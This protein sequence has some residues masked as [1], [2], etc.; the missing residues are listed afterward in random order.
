MTSPLEPEPSTAAADFGKGLALIGYRGTGKSTIG[1][2]VARRAGRKFLDLDREIE[3]R[4]ARPIHAIFLEK[5]EPAFRDLEESVLLDL[6]VQHDCVLA[7]GGGA[8]LRESNRRGLRNFGLIVWLTASCEVLARRLSHDGREGKAR[9]AL[10][11]AG[12]LAEIETVLT[13]RLPLY[14]LAADARVETEGRPASRVAEDVLQLWVDW[15][16]AGGRRPTDDDDR[17]PS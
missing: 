17:E 16:V 5:G 2:L 3:R 15:R 10:T 6:A 14:Q 13:Q 9:P 4:A 8:I 7:T 1:K 12:T 11:S